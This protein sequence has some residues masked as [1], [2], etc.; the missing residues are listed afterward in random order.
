MIEMMR[1]TRSPV[2]RDGAQRLLLLSLVSFAFSVIVTRAF[3]QAT[4]YP[5]I[6]GGT[7][8]IAHVLWGGLLLFIASL[9]PL[10]LAN[11]WALNTAA[12][13][14][15]VGVGLFID[16]VGKFITMNNDY[17]FPAAAPIIYAFFLITV[18]VYIEVKRTTVRTPRSELYRVFEQMEEVL[19]SDLDPRERAA[20][21]ER[22]RSIIQSSDDL[23]LQRLSLALIQYLEDEKLK[24]ATYQP[25]WTLRMQT[26]VYVLLDRYITR[27]KL[28][29]ILVVSLGLL[30]ILS[31]TQ[32]ILL[33][34]A[35]PA[36]GPAIDILLQPM[37]SSGA[38]K[39]AQDAVWFF[40][41]T[42]LEGGTGIILIAS[43]AMM[44]SGRE[45]RAL[46]VSIITLVVW[47]TSINLLVFYLDQFG[48][49][50]TTLLQFGVLVGLLHYRN[51]YLKPEVE[52]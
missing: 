46:N 12:I 39:S 8:H 34:V 49:V 18:F 21:E 40:S 36:P 32:F 51:H 35:I 22:L 3:L 47:L 42:L 50:V 20:L 45:Q 9:L 31:M 26:K 19:D 52:K 14:S 30:G 28:K 2:K 25:D 1:R 6:G 43:G 5:K 13:L 37:V 10:V 4:G 24:L 33:L 27:R 44:T 7:L 15:G 41:R 23:N 17:F 16:E 29:W 11:R 48:A 38:L